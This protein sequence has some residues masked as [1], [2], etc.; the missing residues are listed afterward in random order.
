MGA[1]H[2][3]MQI[4]GKQYSVPP[5]LDNESK[6]ENNIK[7]RLMAIVIAINHMKGPDKLACHACS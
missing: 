6:A 4:D 3:N 7:K 2:M 5:G 1:H